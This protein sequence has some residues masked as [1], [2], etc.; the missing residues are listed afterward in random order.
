[1]WN[2][3]QRFGCIRENQRYPARFNDFFVSP[4]K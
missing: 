4:K 1:L 2:L 3:S